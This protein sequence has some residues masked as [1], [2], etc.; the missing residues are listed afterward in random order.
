[1]PL[2][3]RHTWITQTYVLL[4]LP[5]QDGFSDRLTTWVCRDCP[6]YETMTGCIKQGV[7][8]HTPEFWEREGQKEQR[9]RTPEALQ[10]RRQ[11]RR[12]PS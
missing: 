3:H 2:P 5:M 11:Q 9:R 8:L 7:P 6:A 12:L 10:A 4:S 1:M